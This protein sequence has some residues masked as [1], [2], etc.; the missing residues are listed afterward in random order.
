MMADVQ[1]SLERENADVHW[2][3]AQCAAVLGNRLEKMK[4]A[5]SSM[6]A[7]TIVSTGQRLGP[8]C[9]PEG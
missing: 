5:S 9:A 2:N 7:R 1:G 8:S 3:V 4:E 6:E